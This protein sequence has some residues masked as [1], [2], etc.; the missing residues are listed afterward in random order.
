[1]HRPPLHGGR[2]LVVRPLRSSHDWPSAGQRPAPSHQ[3]RLP[4]TAAATHTDPPKNQAPSAR[5][6]HV[7]QRPKPQPP[8]HI[9]KNLQPTTRT[10][11][12]ARA[13]RPKAPE[14]S[15]GQPAAAVGRSA[16]RQAPQQ[17]YVRHRTVASQSPRGRHNSDRSIAR[18]TRLEL[19]DAPSLSAAASV[20]ALIT[21]KRDRRSIT[22]LPGTSRARLARGLRPPRAP[23]QFSA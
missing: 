7:T 6:A 11:H 18:K 8:N 2:G 12:E 10:T 1:M 15:R 20:R 14:K 3:R 17:R 16:V 23:N 5:P 9:T 4:T 19:V 22:L 13:S 21:Q